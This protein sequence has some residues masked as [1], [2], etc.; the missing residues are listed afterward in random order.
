MPVRFPWITVPQMELDDSQILLRYHTT[1]GLPTGTVTIEDVNFHLELEKRLTAKLLESSPADRRSIFEQC[2]SELYEKLPWLA[3]AGKD[4]EGDRW[5]ALLIPGCRVYEVGSGSGNLSRRLAKA[6]F[7]VNATDI[8]TLRGGDRT[9]TDGVTWSVTDGVRLSEYVAGETFDAVISDQVVE[10]LHPD[11]A[12]THFSEAFVILRPGGRYVVRIPHSYTGPHDVSR[13]FGYSSPIGM[14]L[15]EY[16]NR[17]I[18]VI[19][20]RAGF[21][22]IRA[23]TAIPQPLVPRFGPIF[24]HWL[25]LK[26]FEVLEVVL[27]VFPLS[28]KQ[29]VTR[30]L[31]GALLPRIFL[32]LTKPE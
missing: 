21:V 1:Y 8:T 28:A 15:H 20:K 23:A 29:K 2:Y 30:H 18:L 7:R 17:E 12:P 24:S 19:A 11:D 22:R 10:H 25:V 6:G 27:G 16:T 4:S 13:I 32:V 31:P 3:G 26:Y 9:D 14:H 5:I